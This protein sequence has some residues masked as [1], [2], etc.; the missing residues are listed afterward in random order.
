L[1]TDNASLLTFGTKAA[2]RTPIRVSVSRI[3]ANPVR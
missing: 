2:R 1:V 3:E